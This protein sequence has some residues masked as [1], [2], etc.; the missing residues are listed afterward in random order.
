MARC[1]I[2]GD[3]CTGQVFDH[4]YYDE[5]Y[6]DIDIGPFCDNCVD[7]VRKCS[8]C[9]HFFHKDSMKYDGDGK[10]FCAECSVNM[11]ECSQCGCLHTS[12]EEIN[13]KKICANCIEKY[14]FKCDKCKQLHHKNDKVVDELTKHRYRGYF[15]KYRTSCEYCFSKNKKDY[16]KYD[17]EICKI[18]DC[19]FTPD[20]TL[21][22]GRRFCKE[23]LDNRVFKCHHCGELH[24]NTNQNAAGTFINGVKVYVNLCGDCYRSYTC[25][26]CG[27]Y[28]TDL[29]RVHDHHNNSI[30]L[31]NECSKIV[32]WGACK[33]CN[34]LKQLVDGCCIDCRNLY[35]NNKCV[36]CGRTKDYQGK[37]RV[38]HDTKIY[39]YTLKPSPFFNKTEKD[40]K[41]GEDVFVG[42]ENEITFGS[43]KVSYSR[44]EKFLKKLYEVYDPTI[45]MAKS[46]TSI[47]G[48]GM[49]IVTQPMTLDYFHTVFNNVDHLD[50]KMKNNKSCG[51]H[52]HVSRTGI[53]GDLHLYKIINFIYDNES[54]SEFIAGR[55]Y[56]TYNNK[57]F[58]DKASK[59][60]VDIKKKKQYGDRY[61]RVN[62]SND[63]TVEF[64]MFKT[65]I[66]PFDYAYKV[67]FVVALV[68]W[69]K[70]IGLKD[71]TVDKFEQYVEK[72][73]VTYPN[74][75]KKINKQ[76]I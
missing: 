58:S 31:C 44:S 42:I 4:V 74:L 46:D 17:V 69:T 5:R 45:L 19:Y 27:V 57:A 24:V 28:T 65:S 75:Y 38:C 63:V 30:N 40:I 39:N 14:Y 66:T 76:E 37:C 50:K 68:K 53:K 13:G 64:R 62:I 20:D 8:G 73:K 70:D 29:K 12:F 21:E 52:V 36:I 71:V 7:D 33:I 11:Y 22:G 55:S 61:N 67:E 1:S 9:N 47:D 49:E 34:S 56:T 59:Y 43:F 26:H 25:N 3:N 15:I 35:I 51:M 6:P 10:F 18:C 32:K 2:C 48:E 54:F 16:K 60:L 72:N 41:K 23:C